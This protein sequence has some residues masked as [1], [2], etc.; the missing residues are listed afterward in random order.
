M[1]KSERRLGFGYFSTASHDGTF[2]F[3]TI[4]S[5]VDTV[6]AVYAGSS[7]S[8]L[9]EIT[10]NDD[11]PGFGASR[12]L[13]T[14]TAGA[15]YRVAIDG[16]Q[17][18]RGTILLNWQVAP[19]PR[20]MITSPAR[21]RS[22]AR[23]AQSTARISPPRGKQASHSTRA[24]PAAS[25]FGSRG[26]RHKAAS[27]SSIPVGDSFDTTMAVYTGSALNSL[28]EVVSNDEGAGVDHA[29]LVRF[30]AEARRVYRIAV[31]GFYGQSG[32]V[33][34]SWRVAAPFSSGDNDDF[35]NAQPIGDFSGGII[36][37]NFFATAEG[38]E[39]GARRNFQR[40]SVWYAWTAPETG[41][42]VLDTDGSF[43][44][45]LLAVYVGS[46]VNSLSP[47]ASNDDRGIGYGLSSL[48]TFS[49][50]KGSVYRIAVDGFGGDTGRIVLSCGMAEATARPP[51]MI[52]CGRASHQR[53]ER[54]RYWN[55][56]RRDL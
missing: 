48:V 10:S 22:A 17:A 31:D 24:S 8:A 19:P 43:F 14:A 47:V 30:T 28:I 25:R 46:A 33:T 55:E 11:G 5:S 7:V 56:Q 49:A 21:L 2:M 38:G 54:K 1:P 6:L 16:Y 12:V 18:Q 3:D 32:D 39:A 34:L 45:T 4:N 41:V 50:T 40:R 26:P 20:P 42:F 29:S 51:A 36:G 27:S 13:F 44:D 15:V 52:F 23:A 9:S 37:A 53:S 35:A